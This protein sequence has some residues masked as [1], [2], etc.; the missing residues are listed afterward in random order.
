MRPGDLLEQ[1]Y[2]LQSLVG[3]GRTGEVWLARNELIDRPVAIKILPRDLLT[4]NDRSNRFFAEMRG[5]GR[6]RHPAVV[7]LIDLGVAPQGIFLVMELLK[8]ELLS[9]IL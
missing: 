7:E 1:R 6:V 8:G 3:Q 9:T 5:V 2:R 4:D